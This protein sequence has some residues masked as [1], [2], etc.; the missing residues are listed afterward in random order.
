MGHK[1][2]KANSSTASTP[3]G[4]AIERLYIYW[5]ASTI[6]LFLIAIA[7][8]MFTRGIMQQTRE[9]SA[10]VAVLETKVQ[11]L[12]GAPVAA[13][14]EEEREAVVIAPPDSAAM[15]ASPTATEPNEAPPAIDVEVAVPDEGAVR[16]E[17]RALL[18]LDPV[19]V[20]AVTDPNAGRSL[21]DRGREHIG[22]AA[23]SGATWSGLAVLARLLGEDR[24]AEAFAKRAVDANEPLERYAEVSTRSLL[25]QGQSVAA[26]PFARRLVAE[27]DASPTAIVLL[28]DALWRAGEV[29]GAAITLGSLQDYAPLHVLDKLRLARLCIDLEYWMDLENI[30]RTID[31]VPDPLAHE[32]NFLEAVARG[33]LYG[34]DEATTALAMLDYLRAHRPPSFRPTVPW[35]VP[36]P[37]LYDVMVWRGVVLMNSGQTDAAREALAAAAEQD[38]GRPEAYY[39][40]GILETRA[41]DPAAAM[42]YLKNA[43]ASSTRMV[44][45]W[46]TMALLEID[47]GD[48]ETG[49]Q[50]LERAIEV[51]AQRPAAHFMR[52]IAHAKLGQVEEARSALMQTFALDRGYLDEAEQ[53]DVLTTLFTNAELTEMVAEATESETPEEE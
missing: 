43:V 38:P 16:I 18:A 17:L 53:T 24:T 3:A 21:T 32:R 7:V 13:A 35:G 26:L 36:Q 19:T 11:E 27:T 47:A 31:V 30:L 9:L 52:A 5:M 40:R 51:N 33:A 10:R 14:V 42:N 15:R 29:D 4:G 8:V 37:T 44:P 6:L 2:R 34:S 20:Y 50:H 1:P 45:A 23:W 49:L 12:K 46:E 39:H 22:R 28:A 41:G 25:A 48:V